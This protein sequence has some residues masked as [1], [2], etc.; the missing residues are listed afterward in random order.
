MVHTV[1]WRVGSQDALRF[2][3][4]RLRAEGLEVEA[5]GETVRF[6][7][8]EGL[9]HE[10]VVSHVGDTPLVAHHPEIPADLALQ[11]FDGVRA[12]GR[13]NDEFLAKLGFEQQHGRWDTRAD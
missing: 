6:S 9:A 11:G 13:P 4:D 3:A 12:Y 1:V 8:P 7:N 5:E 2:W 10:L